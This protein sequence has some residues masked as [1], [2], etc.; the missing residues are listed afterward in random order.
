MMVMLAACAG[1][2]EVGE[3]FT[4]Q[5]FKQPWTEVLGMGDNVFAMLERM[6]VT[7]GTAYSRTWN[8]AVPECSEFHNIYNRCE[9]CYI[10]WCTKESCRRC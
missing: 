9:E 2:T 1:E 10:F 4:E 5:L 3:F 7:N 8:C 6:R